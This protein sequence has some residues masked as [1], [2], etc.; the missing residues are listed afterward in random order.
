M[1][2]P[3]LSL[4][5]PSMICALVPTSIQNESELH[6]MSKFERLTKVV[7]SRTQE[8]KGEYACP[9]YTRISLE[10]SFGKTIQKLSMFGSED[11]VGMNLKVDGEIRTH[12]SIVCAKKGVTRW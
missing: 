3:L 1:A 12:L 4:M 8:Q 10:P 6:G 9:V 7:S 2:L 11:A 5:L